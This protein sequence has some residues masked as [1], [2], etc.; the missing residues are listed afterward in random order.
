MDNKNREAFKVY[1][2]VSNFI[3]EIMFILAA[4]FAV[5]YFLDEWLNTLVVFKIIFV[6]LGVFAGLRNFIIRISKV[7]VDKND[8]K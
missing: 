8:E 2:I 5:G 4:S 3:F 1:S 7:G 6:L